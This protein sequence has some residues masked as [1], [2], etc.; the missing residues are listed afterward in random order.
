MREISSRLRKRSLNSAL[1]PLAQGVNAKERTPTNNIIGKPT[2][3]T[4]L[5][6]CMSDKPDANQTTIS[7]S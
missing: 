5:I 2:D 1:L 4:G 6:H 7:E 3:S